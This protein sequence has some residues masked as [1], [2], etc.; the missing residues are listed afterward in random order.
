[1]AF[2]GCGAGD[3]SGNPFGDVECGQW[4]SRSMSSW[5]VL[6]ALQGFRYN[7]GTHTIGFD[8][9]WKPDDHRSFFTA[10]AAWGTFTQHRVGKKG[11]AHRRGRQRDMIQ[12]KYG[13]IQLIKLEL[14]D[15]RVNPN[16]VTVKVGG[17][18]IAGVST[19]VNGSHVSI[20]LSSVVTVKP[21]NP[22]TVTVY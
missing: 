10:G 20:S 8:P 12:V 2:G 19:T 6:L 21:G 7:A 17:K 15:Q 4:Y 16:R 13:S 14:E 18:R 9:V 3:G 22:L 5:S 11:S 1:M